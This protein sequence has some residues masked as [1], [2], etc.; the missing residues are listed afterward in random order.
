[1]TFFK[2]A[3]ILILLPLI[4]LSPGCGKTSSS[5]AGSQSGF[6]V[7]GRFNSPSM[8]LNSSS[9]TVDGKT[10][11]D[12]LAVCPSTHEQRLGTIS[13]SNFSIYIE[14]GK[15][16]VIVFVDS[17]KVGLDMIV[18]KFKSGVLDTLRP[19]TTATSTDLGDLSFGE[20]TATESASAECS[21]DF[22]TLLTAIGMSSSSAAFFGALDDICLRYINPDID[23]NGVMDIKEGLSNIILD[24][25]NRYQPRVS[26]SAVDM[27]Y[28]KNNFLPSDAVFSYTQ[29]G[30]M[31]EIDRTQFSVPSSFEFRFS[32]NATLA[33]STVLAA[34][35][36]KSQSY[37][38]NPMYSERY[39]FDMETLQPP[40]G[41][42]DIRIGERQFT[43]S[44]V[45]VPSLGVR[46][47]LILPFVRFNVGGDNVVAGVSWKW[48]KKSGSTWAEASA[49][50]IDLLVSGDG[51]FIST[52]IDG[53]NQSSDKRINWIIPKTVSGT[54]LMSDSRLENVTLAQATVMTFDRMGHLGISYDDTLGMRYFAF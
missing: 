44:D 46:D 52:Y 20:A 13:T 30:V 33:D 23:N 12:V 32:N 8:R 17:T 24:F 16:W 31:F 2:K 50:E 42:Y 29:T 43:F 18:G 14:P 38:D 45:V 27:S 48:M 25:H 40:S 9:F 11:T 34:N 10:V 26:G 22:D 47:G 3:Y 36:Y 4:L 37:T 21:V 41:V 54:L 35:T 49:S 6:K 5:S 51:G 1:M 7:Q 19:A 39:Q 53:D 28:L 15:P